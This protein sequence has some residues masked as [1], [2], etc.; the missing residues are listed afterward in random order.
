MHHAESAIAK[1][2]YI[3]IIL[4]FFIMSR[5][6]A[7]LIYKNIFLYTFF[8]PRGHQGN[9]ILI[10]SADTNFCVFTFLLHLCSFCHMLS[11]NVQIREISRAS[12]FKKSFNVFI[13]SVT[14]ILSSAQFLIQPWCLRM[15][16]AN[17]LLEC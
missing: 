8:M 4:R 11:N 10:E 12:Q 3:I 2:I 6:Y 7:L 1:I 9:F 5:L 14:R 15:Q 16:F 17:Q 13:Y